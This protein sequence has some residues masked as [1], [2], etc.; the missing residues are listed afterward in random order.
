MFDIAI[1]QFK[2]CVST[3]TWYPWKS[4]H[5]FSKWSDGT[6]HYFITQLNSHSTLHNTYKAENMDIRYKTITARIITY[7]FF[8]FLASPSAYLTLY[9]LVFFFLFLPR[10]FCNGGI[11]EITKFVPLRHQPSHST[12]TPLCLLLK[13]IPLVVWSIVF[14]RTFIDFSKTQNTS[15]PFHTKSD[16]QLLSHLYLKIHYL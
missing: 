2:L 13:L 15:L 8:F 4:E 6:F 10:S 11:Y 7:M 9:V 12:Y 14:H 5:L 3:H 1:F 16:L